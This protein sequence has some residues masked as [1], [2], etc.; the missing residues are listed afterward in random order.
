MKEQNRVLLNGVADG[1]LR[2][3]VDKSLPLAQVG[4]AQTYIEERRNIG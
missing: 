3:H 1:W 2:P 4:E